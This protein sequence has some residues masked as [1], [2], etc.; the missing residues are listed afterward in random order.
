MIFGG[1][2]QPHH[3]DADLPLLM[4]H[5][6][7][8]PVGMSVSKA[9]I[10]RL[11]HCGKQASLFDHLGRALASS[12]GGHREAECLSGL[13]VDDQLKFGGALE[14]GAQPGFASERLRPV[15]RKELP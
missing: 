5:Y 8:S 1:A 3:A 10:S 12:E 7:N 13:E 9:A 4:A 15:C 14:P 2:H 6:T 11:M